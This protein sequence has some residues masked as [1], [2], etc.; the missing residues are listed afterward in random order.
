MVENIVIFICCT[1]QAETS[2]VLREERVCEVEAVDTAV[3]AAT[4]QVECMIYQFYTA[5]LCIV[6][7]IGV[8]D[9]CLRR[10]KLLRRVLLLL[11]P[12]VNPL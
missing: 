7:C 4:N 3:P 2:Q 11:L 12:L 1:L 5:W 6:P 8:N 9:I 10:R